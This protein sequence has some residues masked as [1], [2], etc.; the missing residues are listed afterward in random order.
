MKFT[1]KSLTQLAEEK[2]KL[3]E[4]C[5]EYIMEV[6]NCSYKE[7]CQQTGEFLYDLVNNKD[8]IF[9]TSYSHEAVGCIWEFVHKSFFEDSQYFHSEFESLVLKKGT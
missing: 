1:T 6:K 5:P 2:G 7:A 3:L 4:V 9:I 8:Y